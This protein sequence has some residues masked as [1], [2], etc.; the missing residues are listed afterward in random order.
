[1]VS[2]SD[3]EKFDRWIADVSRGYNPPPESV[4]REEMWEAIQRAQVTARASHHASDTSLR[5]ITLARGA[6]RRWWQSAAAAVLLVGLGIG[7]GRYLP[8]TESKAGDQ[9]ARVVA[10]RDTVPAPQVARSLGYDVAAVQHL[11]NAEAML[12]SFRRE[13][14][15]NDRSLEGW[16]RDLLVDTRLLLDSP[17]ATDVARRNLLEDLELVLAQIVQLPAESSADRSLV[18]RSIDRGEVLSRIRSSIPA[19]VTSGT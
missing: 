9:S 11:A 16:A 8:S 2:M 15:A 7:I 10:S 1:M 4:P 12:T 3:D 5:P 17:A 19:G 13:G 14:L 6:S 18:H